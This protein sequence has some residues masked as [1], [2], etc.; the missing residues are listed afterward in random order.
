[1]N[2]N[3]LQLKF[4]SELHKVNGTTTIRGYFGELFTIFSTDFNISIQI[5][6]SKDNQFGAL[7][8]NWTGMMSDLV[9]GIADI[10]A[11][12]VVT[13]QRRDFV[14]TSPQLYSLQFDVLYRKAHTYQHD[15][16]FFL[17][18]FKMD[19]WF[20]IFSITLIFILINAFSKCGI[21]SLT[22]T[23]FI[24]D[25]V[26]QFL[27][28]WPIVISGKFS[29]FY[30]VKLCLEVYII[31]SMLMWNCYTSTLTSLFST[32][33]MEIPFTSLDDMLTNTNYLAVVINGSKVESYLTKLSYIHRLIKVKNINDAIAAVYSRK[34]AFNYPLIG[35][36]DLI[37][38]NC[39]LSIAPQYTSKDSNSLAYSKKFAYVEYFNNKIVLLKECGILPRIYTSN[40]ADAVIMCSDENSFYSIR[41]GQIIGPLV[42]VF[43]GILVVSTI[44]LQDS[45]LNN[46][47]RSIV[48]RNISIKPTINDNNSPTV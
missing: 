46:I 17:K 7:K 2:K 13:R 38:N 4:R 5:T 28:C 39:S 36:T 27:L 16:F 21:K 45:K 34:A 40:F 18:P 22:L 42:L 26:N 29:L 3:Y 8:G 33:K 25:S 19:V 15:Y 41:L 47:G 31:F 44:M 43:A 10:S 1:M 14:K 6:H 48:V 35:L 20:S 12:I 30:S 9:Y 11:G 23:G 24:N 32:N 37:S